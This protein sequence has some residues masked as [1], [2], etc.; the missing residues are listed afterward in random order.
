MDRPRPSGPV[1]H[2]V[3]QVVHAHHSTV[4]GDHPVGQPEIAPLLDAPPDLLDRRVAVVGVDRLPPEVGVGEPLVGRVAEQFLDPV[5]D[6]PETPGLRVELPHDRVEPRHDGLQPRRPAPPARRGQDVC[7]AAR[8]DHPAGSGVLRRGPGVGAASAPRTG[9][10]VGHTD[11]RST[12][13]GKVT[14]WRP[15]GSSGPV[16]AGRSPSTTACVSRRRRPTGGALPPCGASAVMI[17]DDR[18]PGRRPR[19]DPSRARS[20][21]PRRSGVDDVRPFRTSTASDVD[22]AGVL[23]AARLGDLQQVAAQRRDVVGHPHRLQRRVEPVGEPGVLRRDAGGAGVGV[24]LLR[25]DA[26]DRQHR[27]AGR[28]SPCRSRGRRRRSRCRAGRACRRR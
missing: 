28:R 13:I 14:P 19:A 9:S 3:G 16:F 17:A 5:V 8:S 18:P 7:L 2:D 6:E 15:R 11:L 25:L 20:R 1:G 23:D 21:T 24:A 4:R 22:Q 27:L 10:P 12:D 26:A